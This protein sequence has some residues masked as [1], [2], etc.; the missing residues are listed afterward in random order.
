MAS[1]PWPVVSRD[2]EF[3]LI[4]SALMSDSSGCGIVL[5]GD[6][7]VGKT[8]LARLVTKSLPERVQWIA[9][10][11]SAR[12]IPLGVFAHLVGSATARDMM[13][14]LA[15]ARQTI[16]SEEHSIIGVDDAHLLDQLSATLLHQ[17]ALDGS[18][19]IVA[20]IRDGEPVP[21]AITSLWKDGYL[22]RLHLKPFTKVQCSRLIEQAL[23]GR[24]EG[25]SADL[26]W[27]ASGGNAMFV[28]HLVEGAIE[29]GTLRQ[30][31]GVWQLR[32]RA[33]V[34]SELASL[35]DVRV[36][37]LPPDILHALHLLTF[38]EPLEL[39]ALAALAGAEAVEQA[40]IRGLVR[41][42]EEADRLDVQFTHPLF[43][44]VIRRRLGV[45]AAR[46]VRGELV[47]TLRDRPVVNPGQRIRLAEL[48]LDSDEPPSPDLLVAAARD[49]IALGNI[50]LGER[51]AR[52]AVNRG[53]G[54]PASEL[55][56]R[57][58]LWK[59]E[60]AESDQILTAYDPEQLN[61]LELTLWGAARIANL[62]WSMG[63][64]DTA[65]QVLKLLRSR[66]SHPSL[67]LFLDGLCA[68]SLAFKNQLPD[69][70]RLSRGVLDE[71]TAPASAVEWAI[72]GGALALAQAGRLDEVAA[73]AE[74]GLTVEA[75]VDGL[76]RYLSAF[77]EIRALV[78]A[79]DFDVAE[80]RCGDILRI[81]SPGQ[82]L[83]WGM[84]N[85][86]AGTVQVARGRFGT[87]VA[88]ME[89]TVAALTSESAATWSFPA[90]LLLAQCYCVLGKVDAARRIVAEL[91]TRL[92][93]HVAV[94]EPQLRL[95]EGWLAAS[96][97]TTSLA[98]DKVLE[99]AT[100]AADSG[101]HGFEMMALHDAVRFGER[102]CT[103]RLIEL[104]TSV[105]G[106]LAQAYRDHADAVT[107]GDADAVQH[108]AEEFERLGALL[109]AADAYADASALYRDDDNKRRAVDAAAQ[110]DRLAG[111]CGGI[112]TPALKIAANPL[113]ISAREREIAE[114]IAAGASNKQIAE[115][116]VLSVRTVEGHIYRACAKVGVGD[117]E[118]LG[119]IATRG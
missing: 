38:G 20:T 32:G 17:L 31:R 75:K 13:A 22:Q 59:G 106:A 107:E 18:V 68:A 110:A 90:R 99:A 114:L 47:R 74:R 65:D 78:L 57:A 10:T 82:Y 85:V 5:F 60:A 15:A 66:V 84:A 95:T 48:T 113:P 37:Q 101:Q 33:S 73:V 21:D 76:L 91:R 94:F 98:V 109:S 8:T 70:I 64:A 44:E 4:Q 67:T 16:L 54:F 104:A 24:V 45:A 72:I 115:R 51:L 87:A 118:A 3:K 46:R 61:E 79:G 112:R 30:V 117:R 1:Q 6:A 34:T 43:G 11:E 23:G 92:G 49:A 86:L 96:E 28:R 108:A 52:A 71:P 14:F 62:Q 77:G 105:G 2:N 111:L 102:E 41:I 19:R 100:L 119:Y 39:D 97:G 29:A 103:P 93:R 9:A 116:L 25:L 50:T 63:D 56:A 55:L 35:L 80:R 27:D 81:S 40:E 12:S 83:A 88:A 58:L 89:Q 42:T 7:G 26:I 36:E 69:A 53:G